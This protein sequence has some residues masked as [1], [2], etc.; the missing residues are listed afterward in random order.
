MKKQLS[1]LKTG[2]TGSAEILVDSRHT[3]LHVGSG[4]QKI[5]ATPVLI[6]LM[7]TA[8]QNAVDGSLP[9]GCQTIGTRLDVQHLAAT[10][11]G[12]R[13]TASAQLIG[14]HG[15]TLVFQV[16]ASDGHEKIGDGI[17]ERSMISVESFLRLLNRKSSKRSAV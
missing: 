15:R 11:E 5:L 7:E 6:T 14:M 12:M 1:Q 10:P 3:A 9:E 2:L 4:R 13:V 8:A 17:H 16:S